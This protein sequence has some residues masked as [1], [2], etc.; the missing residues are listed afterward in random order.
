MSKKHDKTEDFGSSD[1]YAAFPVVVTN[2]GG[3]FGKSNWY[4]FSCPSCSC[5]VERNRNEIECDCGERL[6]WK[7]NNIGER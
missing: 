4:T 7:D 1:C 5:Q 3:V 6:K 2:H